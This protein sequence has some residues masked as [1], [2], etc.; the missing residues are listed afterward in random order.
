[1]L[2]AALKGLEFDPMRDRLFSVGDRV[3]RGRESPAVLDAV[4][5]HQIKVV[6][7]NHEQMILD[8]AMKGGPE[9]VRPN[10]AYLVDPQA[11]PLPVV[12]PQPNR[13]PRQWRAEGI[14]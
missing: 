10:R 4:H 7:G 8:W 6:R 5:R 14:G 12:R 1:M 13:A 9:H 3:D 11:H 2:D